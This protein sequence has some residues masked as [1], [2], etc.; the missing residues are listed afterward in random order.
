MNSIC[1]YYHHILDLL[2][3]KFK[4]SMAEE[5]NILKLLENTD[6]DKTAG[7]DNLLARF[8]KDGSDI[9]AKPITQLCNL[10]IKCSV[11]IS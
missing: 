11:L 6:T 8:L 1:I 2:P 10:S 9:L 3:N 5:E 4:F 7:L